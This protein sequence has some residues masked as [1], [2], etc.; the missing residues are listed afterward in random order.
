[1]SRRVHAPGQRF[2]RLTIVSAAPDRLT[3][4]GSRKKYW[5]CECECGGVTQSEGQALRD[6]RIRSCGCL[7]L[8]VKRAR[9][10]DLT[11]RRFGKL[12]A[13]HR[14]ET[15]KDQPTWIC[16]CDCGA[17]VR[18][19]TRY[20]VDGSQFSCGCFRNYLSAFRR[21][22]GDGV[23][24]L[25]MHDRIRS[26]RGRARD[27]ACIDCDKPARD[28]SYNGGDPN[29]KRAQVNGSLLAYSTDPDR[30]SPRCS[31]CHKRYDIAQRVGG[32]A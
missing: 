14:G 29:E 26:L 21:W 31:K 22:R 15:S 17:Q 5:N 8:E 11:G 2:G 4:N 32:A 3:P 25:G 28:W 19:R 23:G 24:Y 9:A 12:V 16:A 10:V 18:I 7:S 13:L 1:M 6:G 27:H 30:Y 20:L